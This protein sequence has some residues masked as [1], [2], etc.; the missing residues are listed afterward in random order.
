MKEKDELTYLK[1]FPNH[2]PSLFEGNLDDIEE[3]AH[4]FVEVWKIFQDLKNIKIMILDPP[5]IINQ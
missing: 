3:F 2:N 5:I 4:V 1:V